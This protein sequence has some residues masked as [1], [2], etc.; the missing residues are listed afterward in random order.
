MPSLYPPLE[1]HSHG[2]LDVG[3]GHRLYWECCGLPAGKPAL[4]LHGG[5]GSGASV[6][7][8]RYFNPELYRI[9]LFDQRGAGRST[10]HA[11]EPDADLSTNTTAHLISDIEKLRDHLGVERWLLYGSSWGAT[12]AQ[13]YAQRHADRIS[14]IVLSSVTMTSAREIE[15]ITRGVGAFFPEAFERFRNGVSEAE[16]EGDLA[17]AYHGLLMSDNPVAREKA[18]RHW[19]DWEI[20]IAGVRKDAKPNPRYEDARFRL[21]FARLVAHYWANRAWLEEGELLR[22]AARLSQIPAVLIHG[23]LDVSG[24]LVTPWLLHRAWPGSRL[25][26]V[27]QAG[28]SASDP[29]MAEAIVAATDEFENRV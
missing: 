27:E 8:R 1:P 29:G 14:E 17:A 2:M 18:A 23:R 22:S 6:N 15:W 19:C 26:A 20:A 11:S 16:R 3:D 4:V 9:I 25:V 7:A 13:A 10:P 5:P 21:G 12:L 28:H 24:P